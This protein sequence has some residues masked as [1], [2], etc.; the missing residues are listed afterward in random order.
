MTPEFREVYMTTTTTSATEAADARS[1]FV[2]SVL[3]EQLASTGFTVS[4]E[5]RAFVFEE[6]LEPKENWLTDVMDEDRTR[7]ILNESLEL[8]AQQSGDVAST[9]VD[10]ARSAFYT[11]IH[12]R[13]HCP[14]PFI[15]C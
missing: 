14:F 15:F 10:L 7:Q 4:D 3:T 1:L 2:D 8:L 5:V 13:W 9:D 11:V 12:D 6:V